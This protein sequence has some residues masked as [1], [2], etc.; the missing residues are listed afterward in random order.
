MSSGMPES[1]WHD[2][3]VAADLEPGVIAGAEIGDAELAIVRTEDG[4]RA[5]ADTCTHAQCPFT[6]FGE[7]EDGVLICNCHG[8]EFNLATGAV[9][10][11]PAEDPL[12]LLEVR[13]SGG[14]LEV[15]LP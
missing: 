15:R 12:A 9:L 8:A 13:E 10:E 2:T 6:E 11:E 1:G 14:R 4:W 5:F 7:V 3:G